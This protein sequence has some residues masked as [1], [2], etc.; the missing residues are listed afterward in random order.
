MLD[1]LKPPRDRILGVVPVHLRDRAFDILQ[2]ARAN[3]EI[4]APE[5]DSFLI[6][7]LATWVL[8]KAESGQIAL[9]PSEYASVNRIGR[10]HLERNYNGRWNELKLQAKWVIDTIEN[11]DLFD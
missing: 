10:R 5:E 7:V 2:K 4:R 11:P 8:E 6:Y 3:D 9:R 1:F